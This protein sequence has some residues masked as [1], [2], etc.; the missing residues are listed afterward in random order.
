MK[1]LDVREL[2]EKHH[3][4]GARISVLTGASRRTVRG[5]L[6]S[7]DSATYIGIPRA[8]LWLLHILLG[9]ATPE[10]IIREA[11]DRIKPK[12]AGKEPLP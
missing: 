12:R 9:E 4:T 2:R 1:F 10:E 8:P 3:L 11:E 7:E 5:W 6:A